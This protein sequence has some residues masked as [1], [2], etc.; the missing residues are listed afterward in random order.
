MSVKLEILG[1]LITPII[2]LLYTSTLFYTIYS[3]VIFPVMS[4]LFKQGKDMLRLSFLKSIKYLSMITIPI[5]VAT[6]F[7]AGDV[8]YPVSYTHL[9]VYKRQQ[10][11]C[12]LRLF[13]SRRH[14]VGGESR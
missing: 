4:K 12:A 8:I 9:D 10:R 13:C 3:A 1:R 14:R 7:Y 5:A 11:G 2:C 6:F